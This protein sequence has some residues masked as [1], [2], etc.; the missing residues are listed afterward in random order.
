MLRTLLTGAALLALCAGIVLATEVKDPNPPVPENPSL[1]LP[2]GPD[3]YGYVCA[4]PC[5][6]EFIDI[7]GTGE[8]ILEGDDVSSGPLVL[9]MPFSF[10][11]TVYNELVFASNGYI[12]TDPTDSGGDLSPDCPLPATP[13]TGGGARIY[14]V[15]D[16]LD[17]EAGIGQGFK[18]F[19]MVCPR[20]GR[21]ENEPCTIFMWDDIAHYPG[22]T[23]APTWDMEVI[24][25]HVTGDIA[26]QIGAGNPEL[27]SGSTTGLMDENYIWAL[28]IACDT[29]NSVPDDACWFILNPDAVPTEN[30]SFGTLKTLYR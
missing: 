13:S 5:L 8:F 4:D 6:Y 28:N 3:D 12:S 21:V 18:Q 22:S 14:P 1:R 16:D 29:A 20:P 15:H 17:L 7:S 11:G 19:F 2:C 9:D 27:G 26:F 25:Y 23:T 10:Y 24:L 30:M